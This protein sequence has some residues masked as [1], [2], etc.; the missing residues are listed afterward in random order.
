MHKKSIKTKHSKLDIDICHALLNSII[1]IFFIEASG[2]GRG[3][4]VLDLSKDKLEKS[5]MLNPDILSDESKNNILKAFSVLKKRKILPIE[6][7]LKMPDRI[8]FD[9]EVL[10]AY[11]ICGLYGR[12]KQSFLEMVITRLKAGNV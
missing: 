9:N 7:E 11:N 6:Q 8:K 2:F 4:G 5:F 10:K 1:G 12:I 3:D